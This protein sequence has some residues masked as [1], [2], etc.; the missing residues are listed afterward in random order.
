MSRYEMTMKWKKTSWVNTTRVIRPRVA[1]HPS[2]QSVSYALRREDVLILLSTF[3]TD[4]AAVNLNEWVKEMIAE[5]NEFA[6]DSAR[7][8]SM[9]HFA[10]VI[11]HVFCHSSASGSAHGLMLKSSGRHLLSIS[12]LYLSVTHATAAAAAAATQQEQN[13]KPS[14][15]SINRL[16]LQICTFTFHLLMYPRMYLSQPP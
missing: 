2:G 13:T 1:Q 12:G 7:L 4:N 5:A 14:A 16:C 10:V 3:N 6:I 11:H 9:T 15:V 8:L